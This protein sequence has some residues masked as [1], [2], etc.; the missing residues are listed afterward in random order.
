[1]RRISQGAESDVYMDKLFGIEIVIKNRIVKKYRIKALDEQLRY[2]RTRSEAKIMAAASCSGAYVPRVFLINQYSLFIEYI[3]GEML[4][5]IIGEK[6]VLE[7][8]SIMADA[9][10]N[11]AALHR[12]NIAHGDYTPANLLLSKS[13]RL[14][15]I[16]F[17]LSQQ[18]NSIEEKAMDLLL[19]KRSVPSEQYLSFED[20]Y[21]KS[22]RMAQEVIN[23]LKHIEVRGRYQTRTL[24]I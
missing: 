22:Y 21:K 7:I 20:S 2:E 4:S 13:K 11:L 18:T 24:A 9:G 17:G 5:R 14:Y 12:C 6:R 10:F 15:V 8:D 23:R 1:M 16:D 3:E 19:M